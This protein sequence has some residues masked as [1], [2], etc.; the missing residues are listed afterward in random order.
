LG[1]L[2]LTLALGCRFNEN[3]RADNVKNGKQKVLMD[4]YQI[5]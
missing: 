5:N 4:F 2:F 3:L 1:V